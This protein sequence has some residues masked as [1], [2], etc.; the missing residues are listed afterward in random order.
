MFFQNDGQ[1]PK[2]SW[3]M[4]SKTTGNVFQNYGQRFWD[5]AGESNFLLL[6]LLLNQHNDK[7][8]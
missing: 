1:R 3:A 7:F 4:F 6:L 5:A 2:K 8:L